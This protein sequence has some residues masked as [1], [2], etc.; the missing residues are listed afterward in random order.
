VE[1]NEFSAAL[2]FTWPTRPLLAFLLL[3]IVLVMVSGTLELTSAVRQAAGQAAVE[4]RLVTGNVQ[5]VLAWLASTSPPDSL[6]RMA[7]DPRLQE[8]LMDGLG[9]APSVLH[10]AVLDPAGVVMAHSEASRVGALAPPN[11]PLPE[12]R[13][14]VQSLEILASL[15][16]GP[17][18][19]QLETPLRLHDRPFASIRV[20]IAGS[21]LWDAARQAASRGIVAA[22]LVISL[23]VLIGILL[24]RV[25]MTRVRL[26]AAGI[27]AIREGR[28][29]QKLPESGIDEFSRLARELNLLGAH[30]ERE[31]ELRG[32]AGAAGP[33]G[34]AAI[35][36]VWIDPSRALTHLG[37]TAAG[38]AHQLSNQLQTVQIDLE[39]LKNSERLAPEEVRRCVEGV[40]QGVE[41]LGGAVRGFLKIARVRPLVPERVRIND[42]IA[43]IGRELHSEAVLSGV[44]LVLE[45]D[46]TVPETWA[47]PEVLRQ[48]VRNLVRNALQAL[49]GSEGRVV[50]RTSLSGGT[51]RISV[52]DNGPGIPPEELKQVFDLYFTTRKDG[53]GIGLALVRQS[54][55]MHGGEVTIESTPGHGTTVI[56][57][58]PVR[59]VTGPG[60]RE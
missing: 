11:P 17:R 6:Q 45:L 46:P 38:V 21:F 37:E 48:A 15:R 40:V 49:C 10:V 42:L 41:G 58:I 47:D 43:E 39:N 3:A 14:F 54:V 25:A 51:A 34:T 20:A 26:L 23:A 27:A 36:P 9:L 8:V 33:P 30:F 60:A 1:R 57:E 44:E 28:F 50:L 12:I 5:R 18:T 53:S 22:F 52:A 16:R 32:K 31:R 29:E 56:L 13:T 55:E 2:R 19:Y 24:S 59:A 7:R 4:A 35:V